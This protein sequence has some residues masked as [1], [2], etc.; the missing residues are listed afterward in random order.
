MVEEPTEAAGVS[1]SPE[2]AAGLPEKAAG[3]LESPEEAEV[4]SAGNGGPA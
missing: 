4:D 2:E 1:A 3:G